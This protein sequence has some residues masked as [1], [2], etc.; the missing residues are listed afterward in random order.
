MLAAGVDIGA[1][2]AEVKVLGAF[3]G[4]F[5]HEGAL[6]AVG[7]SDDLGAGGGVVLG[8]QWDGFALELGHFRELV[9]VLDLAHSLSVSVLLG[10]R[11]E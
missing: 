8:G 9:L 2:H 5:G 3:G 6:V 4:L 7:R 1:H 10:L 11:G